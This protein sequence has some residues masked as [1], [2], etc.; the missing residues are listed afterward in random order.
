MKIITQRDLAQAHK[1]RDELIKQGKLKNPLD[2][3]GDAERRDLRKKFLK[4]QR[5]AELDGYELDII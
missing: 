4:E 1:I 5:K 3:S 2:L